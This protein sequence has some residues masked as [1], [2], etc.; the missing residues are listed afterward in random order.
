MV[1]IGEFKFRQR[2]GELNF[3]KL[4]KID[5]DDVIKEARIGDLQTVLD[6]LVFSDVNKSSLRSQS[7]QDVANLVRMMQLMLEYLLHGQEYQAALVTKMHAKYQPMKKRVEKLETDNAFMKEDIKVYKRQLHGLRARLQAEGKDTELPSDYGLQIVEVAKPAPSV[8]PAPVPSE[9]EKK[10]ESPSL[11]HKDIELRLL[12][13]RLF[14]QQRE[15][16]EDKVIGHSGHGSAVEQLNERMDDMQN[17]LVSTIEQVRASA[18]GGRVT[19]T[20]LTGD[21]PFRKKARSSV[22]SDDAMDK[23]DRS[24]NLSL[25]SNG[26]T[27]QKKTPPRQVMTQVDM[28]TAQDMEEDLRREVAM[29]EAKR[30]AAL[31]EREREV[32]EKL[33]RIHLI[34]KSVLQSQVV[35]ERE[36]LALVEEKY[37]LTP[38]K[39]MQAQMKEFEHS[40]SEMEQQR[41]AE[42]EKRRAEEQEAERRREHELAA[43]N[44]EIAAKIIQARLH[45]ISWKKVLNRFR[46]WMQETLNRRD[47]EAFMKQQQALEKVR[48]LE[49]ASVAAASESEQKEQELLQRLAQ[50]REELARRDRELKEARSREKEEDEKRYAALMAEEKDR[51]ARE[52]R[53][54]VE[55]ERRRADRQAKALVEA[56]RKE[57]DVQT[58]IDFGAVAAAARDEE[59]TDATE[60]ATERM[61]RELGV[62]AGAEVTEDELMRRAEGRVQVNKSAQMPSK[63]ALKED[64][65]REMRARLQQRKSLGDKNKNKDKDR[66]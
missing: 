49:E 30:E 66:D 17:M 24:F 26:T 44:R 22:D 14:E 53:M 13:S 1:S 4:S 40:K 32:N 61:L 43:R 57:M 15:L 16:I 42:E 59:E 11:S 63:V 50:E 8:A 46:K 64:L 58:S 19:G 18:G 51:V 60:R 31:Q 33:A 23:S 3:N 62:E 5:V 2:A 37:A 54:R 65:E 7:H 41:K 12:I 35:M 27:P 48:R 38:L 56:S 52:T 55:E 21:S 47:M 9:E 10:E 45:A 36:R 34:E 25:S 20:P 39:Q 28:K 29:K 6:N